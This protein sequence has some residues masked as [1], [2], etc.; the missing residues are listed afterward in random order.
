MAEAP[1]DLISLAQA[2]KIAGGD[3]VTIWRW[4]RDGRLKGYPIADHVLVRRSEAE[5]LTS[6][7][8]A[9]SR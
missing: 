9:R 3:R 2:D 8:K 4:I 7:K 6:P 1:K 5:R